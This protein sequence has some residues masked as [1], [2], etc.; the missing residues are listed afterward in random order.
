MCTAMK[1]CPFPN[2]DDATGLCATH[3]RQFPHK[4]M[5]Y[6]RDENREPVMDEL[7]VIE[8]K[9]RDMRE[10]KFVTPGAIP[11]AKPI[12]VGMCGCGRPKTH[13]GRCIIRRVNE[14]PKGLVAPKLK[15]EESWPAPSDAL[16]VEVLKD[17]ARKLEFPPASASEPPLDVVR[18]LLATLH[19]KREELSGEMAQVTHAI[20]AVETT[21][22]LL[23]QRG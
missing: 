17:A 3:V 20:N 4:A 9:R 16:P 18:R 22:K 14:T 23:E 11:K 8:D 1:G 15:P 10:Q 12:E 6:Q 7:D 19:T 13:G 2:Q 21:V 5:N